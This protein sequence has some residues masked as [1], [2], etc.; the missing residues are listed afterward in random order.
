MITKPNSI[1][2]L[3]RSKFYSNNGPKSKSQDQEEDADASEESESL[4]GE[5]NEHK[6]AETSPAGAELVEVQDPLEEGK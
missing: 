6:E 3:K 5:N 1:N 4:T 2:D